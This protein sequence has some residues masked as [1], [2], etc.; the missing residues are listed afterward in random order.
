MTRFIKP[1]YHINF[2]YC[3]IPRA[4]FGYKATEK[5]RQVT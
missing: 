5:N 2:K 4:R 3:L 1:V